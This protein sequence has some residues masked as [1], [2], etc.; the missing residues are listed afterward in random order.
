MHRLLPFL[1]ILTGAMQGAIY[2]QDWV[3]PFDNGA[4]QRPAVMSAFA[5]WSTL[6]DLLDDEQTVV[7]RDGFASDLFVLGERRE[8]VGSGY[9]VLRGQSPDDPLGHPSGTGTGLAF[10]VSGELY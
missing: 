7:G 10:V 3:S 9:F 2:G 5:N 8:F 1:I 6:V 4:A